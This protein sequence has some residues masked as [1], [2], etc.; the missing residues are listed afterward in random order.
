MNKFTKTKKLAMAALLIC[1][2]IMSMAITVFA[3]TAEGGAEVYASVWENPQFYGFLGVVA[4]FFGV[5]GGSIAVYF[6]VKHRQ[7]IKE[8]EESAGTVKLYEDLDDARWEEG[9]DTVFLTTLEPT[10]AILSDLQPV[11]KV[12]GLDGFVIQEQPISPT[13]AMAMGADPYAYKPQEEL[14]NAVFEDVRYTVIE[15]GQLVAAAAKPIDQIAV[16]KTSP[17]VYITANGNDTVA[18]AYDPLNIAVMEESAPAVTLEDKVKPVIKLEPRSNVQK[19]VLPK[20]EPASFVA[21]EVPI[22]IVTSDEDDGVVKIKAAVYENTFTPITLVDEPIPAVQPEPVAEATIPSASTPLTYM[23]VREEA[24]VEIPETQANIYEDNVER[25]VLVDE[26]IPVVP[27]PVIIPEVITPSG[28][29]FGDLVAAVEEPVVI[30]ETEA[31]IFEDNIP[32]AVLVDEEKPVIE[33]PQV[34]EPATV[35]SPSEPLTYMA[36]REEEPVEIPETQ[37]NIFEDSVAATMLEDEIKPVVE[38]PVIIPEVITPSTAMFGDL[39]A[40]VEEPVVIPETEANIFEDNIPAAVLEDE[41]KPVVEEPVIIEPATVPSPSDPVSYM[42]VKDEEPVVIPAT[43]AAVYEDTVK[44]TV[45]EDEIIPVVEEPVVIPEVIT[46]STAM[47]GDLVAA[48]E[49]PVV[50][51][52]TEAAVYEDTVKRTVLEDEIIPVV[53]EPVVITP[54]TEPSPAEPLAYMTVADEEPVVIPVTEAAVYE[55]TVKRTVLED[56]IIPVVEEPVYIPDVVTPSASPVADVFVADEEPVVIPVTEAAV[57]EDT[58]KRTVLEDEIIPIYQQPTVISEAATPIA[59][60]VSHT[61][62]VEEEE[63]VMPESKANIYED[64]CRSV[65]EDEPTKHRTTVIDETV[66]EA[67]VVRSIFEV[68]DDTNQLADKPVKEDNLRG[69]DYIEL[70]SVSESDRQ[71]VEQPVLIKKVSTTIIEDDQVVLHVTEE[72]RENLPVIE[73]VVI[74]D[75]PVA[76]KK[77][78]STVHIST[79]PMDP[80]GN[81]V[82]EEPMIPAIPPELAKGR[83]SNAA[84]LPFVLPAT[85]EGRKTMA[86]YKDLLPKEEESSFESALRQAQDIPVAPEI[87][88]E[89]RDEPVEEAPAS[90]PAP[91]EEPK[92]NVIVAD[93]DNMNLDFGDFDKEEEPTPEPEVIPEP[94][95]EPEEEPTPEPEVIPEPVEEPEEEPVV[96]EP[97]VVPVEEPEEE[98]VIEAPVFTDAEHADE[99]MTDEEA[100]EHIEIIEEAPGKERTGKLHAIN[101]DTLCESFEDGEEVTL[102]ALKAKKLAPKNAGRVKILARGTMTKKLDIVADNFSLQAVKMITLAGG[103]A[104]QFK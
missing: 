57:Y 24:P 31:N 97:V 103:R 88:L 7:K 101:L 89:G 93:P 104:E 73:E 68:A 18:N 64:G 4:G 92:P 52:V 36:V 3:E 47:Y 75:E 25:S 82:R 54:A 99:L 98:P 55:D 11:K 65:L 102:E 19:P 21:K 69:Y 30:P 61:V 60:P 53:E 1:V 80:K 8:Y 44:R 90:A 85:E 81:V 27:E 32:A 38:E 15:D 50:I 45:L 74:S 9:P 87:S 71:P 20:A 77:P 48:V 79:I 23:A 2:L 26:I 34:I 40:A 96:E 33:I 42:M 37:A 51:P 46:P 66:I 6:A 62:V 17:S 83:G 16:P 95:E 5:V 49:E 70:D 14:V 72:H 22:T 56:E 10:A 76:E 91:A 67:P 12:P 84:E 100:E 28:D 29:M 63:V 41:I 13:V 43:E 94:V 59:S 35:A 39:V 58:V 78:K 86:D